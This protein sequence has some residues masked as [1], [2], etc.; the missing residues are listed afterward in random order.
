MRNVQLISAP[1]RSVYLRCV[2]AAMI[3]AGIFASVMAQAQQFEGADAQ[4]TRQACRDLVLDY[5]YYRDLLDAD[6]VAGLFTEDATMTVL[7]QTYEGRAAIHKRIADTRQS[8]QGPMTRHLMSTIRIFPDGADKASGV[9]YVT[10]YGAP[11]RRIP[12]DVEGFMA[13]GEYRDRFVLTQ[14]GWKIAER[15]FVPV[16]NYRDNP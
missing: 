2:A 10:V 11:G 8:G 13:V 15:I 6:A 16:F 14:S 12:A 5:A 1:G 3:T 4:Q 9:S 7:G